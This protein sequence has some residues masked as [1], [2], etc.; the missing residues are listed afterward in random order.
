M[1]LNQIFKW[2]A[3]LRRSLKKE[4]PSL[5][6]DINYETFGYFDLS[7]YTSKP[8]WD[9]YRNHIKPSWRFFYWPVTVLT[10]LVNRVSV[11]AA[12]SEIASRLSKDRT[13]SVPLLEILD[14]ARKI[15]GYEKPSD[16]YHVG[17]DMENN[18]QKYFKILKVKKVF[19]FFPLFRIIKAVKK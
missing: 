6:N 1:I 2:T 16:H 9:S 12:Q 3:S 19:W 14:I 15:A 4:L 11:T 18:I 8:L 17:K 5:C 7:P 13:L 10:D